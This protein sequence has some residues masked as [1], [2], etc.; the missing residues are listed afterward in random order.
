MARTSEDR[1]YG[2]G[3]SSRSYMGSE[4]VCSIVGRSGGG[5]SRVEVTPCCEG[6]RLLSHCGPR[7]REP[8]PARPTKTPDGE[9]TK[10]KPTAALGPA[11]LRHHQAPV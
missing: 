11:A 9:G 2:A 5:D 8:N 3:E 1:R 4:G 7:A 6:S 10:R